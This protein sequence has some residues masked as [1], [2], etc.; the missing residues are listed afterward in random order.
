M[1]S[2]VLSIRGNFINFGS[3]YSVCHVTERKYQQSATYYQINML[4]LWK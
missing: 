3:L 4:F 1:I 2:F